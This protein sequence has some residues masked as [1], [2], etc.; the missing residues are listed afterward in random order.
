MS[1]SNYKFADRYLTRAELAL[2]LTARGYRISLSTLDKLAMP[3]CGQ[4]PPPAGTWT[5]RAYY[6]PARALAWAHER[7]RTSELT[8]GRRG[9]GR[10]RPIT[11]V[12]NGKPKA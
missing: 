5:G 4:G 8:K 2:F 9:A 6:D 12:C 11:H 10:K 3:S 1:P 7:F